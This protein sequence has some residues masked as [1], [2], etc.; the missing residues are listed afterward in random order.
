MVLSGSRPMVIGSGPSTTRMPSAS[1]TEAAD[2]PGRALVDVG[3]HGEAAP[4]LA[5]VLHHRH[6]DRAHE[7]VLLGAGMLAGGLL[8]LADQGV[9]EAL[10][11]VEIGGGQ[12][13]DEGIGRDQPVDAQAPLQV[14]LPGHPAPDLHRMEFAPEGLGEGAVD[15]ALEAPF[16]LLQSH[17]G[18]SLPVS[19]PW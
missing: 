10:E 13:D 16:E 4:A 3:H 6:R 2:Q 19:T 15:H 7:H 1:T 18:V 17:G 12:V 5:G 11:A 9:Q 14:H 8:E